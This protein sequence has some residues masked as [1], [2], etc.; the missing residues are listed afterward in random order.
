MAEIIYGAAMPVRNLVRHMPAGGLQAHPDL[1][2]HPL[3]TPD[4]QLMLL[5][6]VEETG[7]AA[8]GDLAS[9]IPDHPQPISA[10]IA[11]VDA[12]LLG[13]DMVSAFDA[14]CRV[15]RRSSPRL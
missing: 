1:V 13:I 8:L 2:D 11:L 3:I 10:V 7:D 5:A 9:A 6:A 14:S 12:G 4:V 15:W